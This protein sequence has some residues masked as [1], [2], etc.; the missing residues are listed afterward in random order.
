MRLLEHFRLAPLF[1]RALSLERTATWRKILPGVA[2]L[3]M[4]EVLGRWDAGRTID[5]VACFAFVAFC[6]FVAMSR[7]WSRDDP[8]VVR[9]R[10]RFERWSDAFRLDS[11]VDLRG[12][13]PLPTRIPRSWG[14][15]SW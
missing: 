6:V 14:W 2:F 10:A 9:W 5:T 15:A 3:V 12:T 4:L 1:R 8:L 11:G 13:P 7:E